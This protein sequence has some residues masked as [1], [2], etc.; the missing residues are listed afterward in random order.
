MSDLTWEEFLT[1]LHLRGGSTDMATSKTGR[2]PW[3]FHHQRGEVLG[4]VVIYANNAHGH[5]RSPPRDWSTGELI[6]ADHQ[7]IRD[8]GGSFNDTRQCLGEA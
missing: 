5:L 4:E 3:L 1:E 6:R 8:H 7:A 2:Y